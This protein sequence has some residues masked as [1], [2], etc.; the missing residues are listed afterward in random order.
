MQKLY[1]AVLGLFLLCLYGGL[2]AVAQTSCN[3]SFDARRQSFLASQNSLVQSLAE[4]MVTVL[5]RRPDA[6]GDLFSTHAARAARERLTL[7]LGL[8][9]GSVWPENAAVLSLP[10]TEPGQ[11]VWQVIQK[12]DGRHFLVSRTML[13][14]ELEGYWIQIGT[15]IEDFY[16][17]WRDTDRLFLC[18]AAAVS[19]LFAVG[20]EL[21]LVRMSRPLQRITRAANLLAAGDYAIRA[22][23]TPPRRDEFGE[24][25]YALDEMAAKVDAQVKELAAEAQAKQM[26]VDDLSHE[27]RTP[28]TAIAGYAEYIQRADLSAEE[29]HSATETISFESR[30]LLNLSNQLV[31][32]SVLQHEP[33]DMVLVNMAGLLQRVI[34]TAAPKAEKRGV[35]L[36]I[37]P[38]QGYVVQQGEPDLLE[39]LFVNLCDNGIKACE[40]GGRVTLAARSDKS[41]VTVTVTDTGCGMDEATLSRI[42][43]PFYRADKARSRAEGGAGLGL[44]LCNAIAAAH[45]ADVQ[46]ASEPG[47]GTTVTVHFAKAAKK[48]E[49]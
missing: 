49:A 28:L 38:I 27:M 37:F 18:L 42:G 11:R 34:R 44:A 45:N 24:V 14:G 13:G 7:T 30:R 22:S 26:L 1:L 21:V 32:L 46:F 2:F 35:A 17:Q 48:T 6:L 9:D 15:D 33:L 29:L 23:D 3:L 47:H 40:A 16:I 39:S 43:Q 20:L 8:P 10:S 36:R 31:R 25:A 19:I 12:E 5:G 41:G 4:D